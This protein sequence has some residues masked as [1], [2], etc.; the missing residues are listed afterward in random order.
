MAQTDRT[1]TDVA[2]RLAKEAKVALAQL[3]K[4]RALFLLI[5]SLGCF[6]ELLRTAQDPRTR[7]LLSQVRVRLK[8]R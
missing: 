3:D 8:L 4:P 5:R 1:M 2:F 6:M 7:R